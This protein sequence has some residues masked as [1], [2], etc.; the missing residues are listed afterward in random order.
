MSDLRRREF[1]KTLLAGTTGLACSS[2]LQ[3]FLTNMLLN[4]KTQALAQTPGFEHLL[5]DYKMINFSMAGGAARYYWDNPMK[6]NGNT[7]PFI[8]S[9]QV[10]TELRR[11]NGVITGSYE[12]IQY[13]GYYLP[14][15]W[16]CMVPT[17]GGSTPMTTLAD[18]MIMIRG[19][20]I[21]LDSH[22]LSAKLHVYPVP[23]SSLLGLV[24]ENAKTP[25]PA[26]GSG[27]GAFF[28]SKK[29]ITYNELA[30]SNPFGDALNPFL[31]EGI[32]I[33]S[34]SSATI[35]AEI[36]KAIA[37]MGADRSLIHPS[38]LSTTQDRLNAKKLLKS[39]FTGL[40]A[41]FSSLLQK[42]EG[43]ISRAFSDE[44]KELGIDTFDFVIPGDAGSKFMSLTI[45]DQ[46]TG[47]DIKTITDSQTSISNLANGMA[48]AEYMITKGFS[49]TVSVSTG[50]WSNCLMNGGRGPESS[51][52]HETGSWVSL[53][54]NAG[55]YRAYSACLLELIRQL[56]SVYVGPGISMFD[57]TAITLT[58]DFN[59][60][61]RYDGSGSDHGWDG[62]NYTIISGMV[63]RLTVF[64]NVTS[65]KAE[66]TWTPRS[67]G[68]WGLGAPVAGLG[69]K[70]ATI[71][72]AASTLAT[73]LNF[74]SPT[75]NDKS[76]VYKNS[77]GKV[78]PV[79]GMG[80]PQNI[81]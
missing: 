57:R 80:R 81:A 24:A 22:D 51:D 55:F 3:V 25:L 19:I 37:A 43:L 34:I 64:G 29:G 61:A 36:D 77:E 7:D 56:K 38:P 8:P 79:P 32:N 45:G 70:I 2:P 44:F 16:K 18:N 1:L 6:P 47:P 27:G 21:G 58:G 78:V 74:E 53:V 23:G 52:P 12:N 75:P 14:S 66:P 63:P 48:I 42:Y 59:R 46:Y 11:V 50:G 60:S 39:Q 26:I 65:Y 13:G 73:V 17:V 30:G 28:G 49:S 10:I 68:T 41:A 40:Q 76:L 20:N 35:E 67:Y 4:F 31:S 62:T 69:G 71:G 72:N 33:R 9:Q 54:L 15:I 5:N